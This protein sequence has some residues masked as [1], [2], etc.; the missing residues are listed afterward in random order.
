MFWLQPCAGDHVARLGDRLHQVGIA[1]GQGA[2]GIE[3]RA[4]LQALEDVEQ[5]PGADLG[6]VLGPRA[7]LQVEHAGLERIAHRP[8]AGRRIVGPAFE[9]DADGEGERLVG[10]P[11]RRQGL[12]RA[13]SAAAERGGAEGGHDLAREGT[14]VVRPTRWDRPAGCWWRRR[15][16]V[17]SAARSPRRACRAGTRCRPRRGRQL[18][19][20]KV[21]DR[22]S[23]RACASRRRPRVR[24]R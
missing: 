18:V 22:R 4:E 11:A 19:A 1:L 2:A 24:S 20:R 7:C 21:A 9:H 16:R 15:P 6:S 14:Q 13:H 17:P 10:R 23:A 12:G 3:H 8:D 5:P